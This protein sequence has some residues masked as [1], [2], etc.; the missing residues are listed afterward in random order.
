[1]KSA[2][3]RKFF[4][5]VTR[6]AHCRGTSDKDRSPSGKK[7][8]ER[9][10]NLTKLLRLK[11]HVINGG[12]VMQHECDFPGRKF[13]E[14]ALP[15]RLRARDQIVSILRSTC[16]L[17]VRN[18]TAPPALPPQEA[19]I[20]DGFIEPGVIHRS[21]VDARFPSV[22]VS[23]RERRGIVSDLLMSFDHLRRSSSRKHV[24]LRPTGAPNSGSA[25]EAATSTTGL[26]LSPRQPRCH[27]WKRSW[28]ACAQPR[29]REA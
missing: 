13:I 16:V 10:T 21:S 1:M 28:S 23:T 22:C 6:P 20:V 15:C 9:L 29:W 18:L 5:H 19:D 26:G 25:I 27:R 17:E 4:K 2:R 14:I 7:I 11:I 12:D 24:D 8:E 3:N